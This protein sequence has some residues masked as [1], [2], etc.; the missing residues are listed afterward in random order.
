ME[1]PF[2]FI[3]LTNCAFVATSFCV[4]RYS[5]IVSSN[6][7]SPLTFALVAFALEKITGKPYPEYLQ[8]VL[9]DPL[10]ITYHWDLNEIYSKSNAAKGYLNGFEAHKEDRFSQ[11]NQLEFLV[12][13]H[14]LLESSLS[15]PVIPLAF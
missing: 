5:T 1:K 15:W 11:P 2:S 3:S 10:G 9:G 12:P 4:F 6:D 8:E 7:P 13:S 14:P